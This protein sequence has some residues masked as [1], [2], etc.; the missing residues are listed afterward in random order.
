MMGVSPGGTSF[1]YN[2]PVSLVQRKTIMKI[3]S[4][5]GELFELEYGRP[6]AAF[7]FEAGFV[8]RWG[9]ASDIAGVCVF[10]CSPA[11]AYIHGA[12]L[13]VDGGWLAR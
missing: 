9:E 1:C 7:G 8:R 5:P 13:P 3:K 12:I 10:L 11:A 2:A 4:L 6:L